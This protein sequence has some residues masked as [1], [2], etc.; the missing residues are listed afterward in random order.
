MFLPGLTA[1]QQ[2][3]A[4]SGIAFVVGAVIYQHYRSRR[5]QQLYEA[6]Q[7]LKGRHPEDE[8]EGELGRIRVSKPPAA[9]SQSPAVANLR[10]VPGARPRRRPPVPRLNGQ[11]ADKDTPAR[12]K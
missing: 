1:L 9:T 3:G 6:I 8:V 7:A 2:T 5:E 4:L 12:E 11:P 10:P